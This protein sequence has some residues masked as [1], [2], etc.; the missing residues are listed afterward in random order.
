M[1]SHMRSEHDEVLETIAV[2]E[3]GADIFYDSA[4]LDEADAGTAALAAWIDDLEALSVDL[5]NEVYA[6]E[7][8][9]NNIALDMSAIIPND[10]TLQAAILDCVDPEAL[11]DELETDVAK[12]FS[13]ALNTKY[14]EERGNDDGVDDDGTMTNERF[15]LMEEDL[16][17]YLDDQQVI[18]DAIQDCVEEAIGGEPDIIY[19][20]ITVAPY[21]AIQ[22]DVE[23]AA[24]TWEYDYGT[25]VTAPWSIGTLDANVELE[26]PAGDFSPA[27][28][29]VPAT[30]AI[31][32]LTPILG[33]AMFDETPGVISVL[34]ALSVAAKSNSSVGACAGAGAVFNVELLGVSIVVGTP[35]A[36][37]IIG[38]D[39]DGALEVLLGL[40]GD[41]CINAGSGHEL[42]IGGGG[43][44]ELH[45][46]DQ[47]ELIIG[48]TGD[49]L[50]YGGCGDSYTFTVAGVDVEV[51]LG[52][53]MFGGAD[54]DLIF[55]ADPTYDDTDTNYTGQTDLIFGDGINGEGGNDFIDGGAGTDFLFG[56]RG[57]DTLIN[58]LS[59]A[60]NID[61]DDLNFG[62][63]HFAGR[64][65]DTIIG[66]FSHDLLVGSQ[67][68]DDINAG[69]GVD[70]LLG[71]DGS[72]DLFGEGGL[73]FVIG[74]EGDDV[75]DGGDGIDLVVG[76]QGDDTASGGAGLFDL[77]IGNGGDD[78]LFGNDGMDLVLAGSGQD[79]ADGNDGIDFVVGST[80]NDSLTGGDGLDIL[81]GGG[82]RDWIDGGN[83]IDLLV[84]SNEV[85]VL[86][87]QD[88]LDVLLGGEGDDWIDGGD[89]TD[90][91]WGYDGDDV[92]FGGNG[93]DVLF[94]NEN[95]DCMWGEDSTDLVFGGGGDDELYG[96][97]SLDLVV[98][99]DGEDSLYGEDGTDILLGSEDADFISGGTGID[100]MFGSGST[101][102]MMGGDDLDLVFSGGSDDCVDGE[103]GFDITFSGDGN[104]TVLDADV[105]FGGSGD[106]AIEVESLGFGNGGDD[107]LMTL[108]SS[109]IFGGV[110]FGNDGA[111]WLF[112]EANTNTTN[113]LFG[114]SDDDI[115]SA[116][117]GT[118]T[119][120]SAW[121][122]QISF[123]NTDNDWMQTSV[124][125]NYA[126]GNRG[127]DIMSGDHDGSDTGEDKADFLWGNRDDDHMYGDK[128]N[129]MDWLFRGLGS[130]QS[131]TRS[132][133]PSSPPSWGSIH[134]APS[135]GTCDPAPATTCDDHEPPS[136]V[137][138]K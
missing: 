86:I 108:S 123:G 28:W 56:Q 52:S 113:L 44:D 120:D 96:G 11:A 35:F 40:G 88:G 95:A 50:I 127:D 8:I 24:A 117:G 89:S 47:H 30:N 77:V 13:D 71:G 132:A 53:V 1:L 134:T 73:D 45:G 20:D 68:N 126:F 87:G 78:N 54:D 70:L 93:V 85:D 25:A 74:S 98:G 136:D 12:L 103:A 63:F 48:S 49:D 51:D 129:S 82:D 18:Y 66:S 121:P 133:W 14:D 62:S 102:T 80:G 26:D 137:G 10:V 94:G 109:A 6:D 4:T 9:A 81:L 92:V 46:G 19:D 76:G 101:D 61:G 3:D 23:A 115:I 83:G 125:R 57:D 118:D 17:D 91:V 128:S 99:S 110:L 41:D 43:D 42:I 135:F 124:G 58:R 39:S 38:T 36:D 55:G 2:L 22:A 116:P 15:I 119:G 131:K 64:G 105:V 114:N 104:D 33:T 59:G 138:A 130:G 31:D 5:E 90:L 60:V 16:S 32:A 7:A 72:D 100:I 75:L 69:A 97:D 27:D 67:D 34:S 107:T 21:E 29:M 122:R 111:D 37:N 79:F 106:D 65:D 112:V 84:G